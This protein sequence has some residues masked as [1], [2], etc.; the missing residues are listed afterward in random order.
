MQNAD[1][2]CEEAGAGAE[3]QGNAAACLNSI[4]DSGVSTLRR[5]L[6]VPV[7]G[8]AEVSFALAALKLCEAMLDLQLAAA[9]LLPTGA[10]RLIS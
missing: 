4:S 7:T 3:L 5:R 10:P 2:L 1:E 8:P 6:A 9:G